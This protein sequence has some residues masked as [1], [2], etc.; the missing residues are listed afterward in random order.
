MRGGGGRFLLLLQGIQITGKAGALIFH[1]NDLTVDPGDFIKTEIPEKSGGITF[2]IEKKMCVPA[3][4][5][6]FDQVADN[7]IHQS[8][9]LMR[10]AHCHAAEGISKTASGCDQIH[11]VII[12]PAGII[13]VC[14]S[15]DP[16]SSKQL[17]DQM[18]SVFI[19]LTDL[20]DNIIRHGNLLR[21]QRCLYSNLITNG[22]R[23]KEKVGFTNGIK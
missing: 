21:I 20:G 18:I 23:C 5:L 8:L 22:K 14:I 19:C 7:R 10:M 12:H 13:Q 3:G 4:K 2:C 16:L 9:A 17:I 1:K 15:S 6:Y 11:L